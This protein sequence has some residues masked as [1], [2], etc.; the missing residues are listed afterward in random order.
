MIEEVVKQIERN[1]CVEPAKMVY[2]DTGRKSVKTEIDDDGNEV[3]IEVPIKERVMVDAKFKKIIE[4]IKIFQVEKDGE[5]HEF[6][7]I[8]DAK[9][10]LGGK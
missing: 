10:F 2:K 3:T 6:S 8:I 7:D 4:E 9:A 5:I 1:I